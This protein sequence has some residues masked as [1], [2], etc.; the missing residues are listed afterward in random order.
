MSLEASS[1]AGHL[2]AELPADQ[3]QCNAQEWTMCGLLRLA[4][5][6]S[7]LGTGAREV[8]D[9]T[10]KQQVSP[11]DHQWQARCQEKVVLL[12]M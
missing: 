6:S 10:Y 9:V 7:A 1:W 5:L 8:S 12:A 3:T 11:G 2:V 4:E